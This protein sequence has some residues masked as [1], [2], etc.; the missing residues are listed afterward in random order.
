MLEYSHHFGD[1]SPLPTSQLDSATIREMLH[2]IDSG[3]EVDYEGA[4]PA[5]VRKQLRIVLDARA[6]GFL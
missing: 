2:W 3:G 4:D 5:D 1:T 6:W